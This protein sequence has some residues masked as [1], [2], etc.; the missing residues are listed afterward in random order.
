M[1]DARTSLLAQ[2]ATGLRDHTISRRDVEHVLDEVAP[3]HPSRP[4]SLSIMLAIGMVVMYLG[5]VLV[6]A[7]SFDD[8][9]NTIQLITPYVFPLAVLGSYA[10]VAR[11]TPSYWQREI[12]MSIALISGVAASL[13]SGEGTHGGTDIAWAQGCSFGW[14]VAGCA[15]WFAARNLRSPLLLMCGGIA[16]AM[17]TTLERMDYSHPWYWPNLTLAAILVTAGVVMWNV[18]QRIWG[19]VLLAVGFLMSYV[20]VMQ[21]FDEFRGDLDHLTWGH[22]VLSIV[23]ATAFVLAPAMRMPVLYVPSVVGTFL[24]IS[25]VIPVATHSAWWAMI[26]IAMG[27]LLVGASILGTMLRRRAEQRSMNDG[28]GNLPT[29]QGL[30]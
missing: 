5:V 7:V 12:T 30:A 17:N 20:G 23:V 21:S 2:L 28:S 4:S 9:N 1:S 19:E 6:Y 16:V 3:G 14:I 8:F 22:V 10:L 11:R 18:R 26:V 13:A 27:A 24:W 15:I 25:T 29:K